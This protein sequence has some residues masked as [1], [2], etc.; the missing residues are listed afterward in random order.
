MN[1]QLVT[2]FNSSRLAWPLNTNVF[3]L[4]EKLK[5]KGPTILGVNA[6]GFYLLPVVN[7][8]NGTISLSSLEAAIVCYSC[9][10]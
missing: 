5:I 1:K 7:R 4:R 9:N 6:K 3:K 2:S 8:T 10:S